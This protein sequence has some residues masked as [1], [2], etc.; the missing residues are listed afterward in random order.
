MNGLG[1]AH[2]HTHTHTPADES[3]YKKPDM[4]ARTWFKDFSECLLLCKHYSIKLINF[5]CMSIKYIHLNKI[6]KHI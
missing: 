2:T 4:Q 5:H 1:G 3:D 6:K